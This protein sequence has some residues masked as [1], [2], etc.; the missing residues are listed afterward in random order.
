MKF[1]E[2]ILKLFDM[3]YL[4]FQVAITRLIENAEE[5]GMDEAVEKFLRLKEQLIT[6]RSQM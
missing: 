3:E 4:R 2:M 5:A 1:S 6:L